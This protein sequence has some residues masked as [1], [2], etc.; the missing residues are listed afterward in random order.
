MC[1]RAARKQ[2]RMRLGVG[3][4]PG[5]VR[6]STDKTYVPKELPQRYILCIS[7]TSVRVCRAT[8]R[9]FSTRSTVWGQSRTQ[10]SAPPRLRT[11]PMCSVLACRP[12]WS[13]LSGEALS[14]R[15]LLSSPTP[16][17]ASPGHPP[18]MCSLRR[19]FCHSSAGTLTTPANSLSSLG[20]ADGR[21][22][23][24]GRQCSSIRLLID[25]Y[26]KTRDTLT[27]SSDAETLLVSE[28]RRS[29]ARRD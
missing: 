12:C 1:N 13:G 24:R 7:G 3:R 5:Q 22:L 6:A 26:L 25:S 15:R 10:P 2:G 9:S 17:S 29:A 21:S 27:D 11:S 8:A 19:A 18:A 16:A 28:A 4:P 20:R 23:T 14:S